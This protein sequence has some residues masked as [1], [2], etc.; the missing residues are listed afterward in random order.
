M[1][2]TDGRRA[3]GA[4]S[5]SSVMRLAVNRASIDGLAGLTIGSLALG[6][7]HSKSGVSGL[8]GTKEQLQLATVEA[9]REIFVEEVIA[10]ALVLA[11]GRE[12]LDGLLENWIHY[13][14]SRVFAGG[15]FFAAAAAELG[16][17]P[18]PVRDAVAQ[19]SLDW[20]A[21]LARVIQRAVERGEL[22]P[23][24]DMAQTVFETRA[25]LDTANSNSLLFG[26]SAPY[27]RARTALKKLFR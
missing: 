11:G 9:A 15:C 6:V 20:D 3:R 10:P 21:T 13:S 26:S 1:T 27:D 2:I 23:I 16:S 5:R 18:G 8:F 19:A 7:G 24:D 25:I 22:S 14:E 12:R 4:V 17:R